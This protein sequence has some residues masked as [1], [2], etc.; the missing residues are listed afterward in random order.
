[1]VK[2]RDVSL[3]MSGQRSFL[4]E[5]VE[6]FVQFNRV[7]LVVNSLSHMVGLLSSFV[8]SD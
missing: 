3:E 6:K 5:D 8:S 2:R 1:M 4:S 7:L